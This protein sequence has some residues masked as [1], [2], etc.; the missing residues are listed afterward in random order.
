MVDY[1]D[2]IAYNFDPSSYFSNS[3][4]ISHINITFLSYRYNYDWVN[5]YNGF[6]LNVEIVRKNFDYLKKEL[7]KQRQGV[8]EECDYLNTD[9]FDKTLFYY[10]EGMDFYK[11]DDFMGKINS[12]EYYNILSS[13][14]NKSMAISVVTLLAKFQIVVTR[15][16]NKMKSIIQEVDVELSSKKNR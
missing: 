14:L 6:E 1:L 2:D 10:H 4:L 12:T 3:D 15:Y 13:L 9:I 16:M 5:K 11:T 8:N 7:S